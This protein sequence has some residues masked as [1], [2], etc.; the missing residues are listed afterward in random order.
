[1][2]Y[3]HKYQCQKNTAIIRNIEWHFT[4]ESWLAW[5]GDDIVNRGR[6]H[7]QLV[8]ARIGDLGP[9]H[10][11]NVRKLTCGE[12]YKEAHLGR[13]QS[14]ETIEKIR[15]KSL[16]R[17]WTEEQKKNH[18]K[19][20]SKKIMTPFGEFGSQADAKR[21]KKLDYNYYIKTRPTEY[22]YI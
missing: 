11:S 1:M 6:N 3:K 12:N 19:S 4:F 17:K 16:G 15:I 14:L 9:Y 10:P 13:K 8:M 18:P 2:N 5:W 7:G 21:F 20:S 22:Y